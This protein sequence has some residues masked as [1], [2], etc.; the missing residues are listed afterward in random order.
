MPSHTGH[1]QLRRIAWN[2]VGNEKI[3]CNRRPQ[4]NKI[5]TN[6]T[7]QI[8]HAYLFQQGGGKPAP[9]IHGW[10]AAPRVNVGAGLAPALLLWRNFLP[11]SYYFGGTCLR[12]ATLAR[13]TPALLLY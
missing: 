9:T 6:S 2:Q 1:K 4:R 8:T 10:G 7:K 13:L 3:D 5:K 11:P 12:P